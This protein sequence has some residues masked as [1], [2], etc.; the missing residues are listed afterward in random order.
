MTLNPLYA[1]IKFEHL[2]VA[3][4]LSQSVVLCILQ[5]SQG[6]MW[7]GTEDGLNKYDGY[8]FTVYKHDPDNSNSLAD[9]YVWSIHE[10]ESGTLWI[11]TSNGL[12]KFD[13]AHETFVHYQH[14]END[15]NSLSHN[16]VRAIEEDHT[17]TLWIGTYGGGL[18]K[19]DRQ[20]EKFVRYQH[21]ENNPHSLSD[22]NIY[23]DGGLYVDKQGSLWIGTEKGGLNKFDRNTD[24]FIHYQHDPKDPNSL[25]NIYVSQIYEDRA[26]TLW[27]ATTEGLNKFDRDTQTFMHYLDDEVNNYIYEDHA[28]MLWIGT[29]G[30][31]LYQFNPKT[32][33]YV[34]YQYDASNPDSLNNN[35]INTIYQ[36][37]AGTLWIGTWGGGVNKIDE[38]KKFKVYQHQANNPNSLSGNAVWE[39][40]EDSHGVLWIGTE[41]S[42]LN[43]F[44][45]QTGKFVHYQSDEKN[46]NS[47][48][49][50]NIYTITEGPRDVLW[51]GTWGGMDKFDTKT[52]TFV[53]YQHD[54]NSLIDNNINHI[55]KDSFGAL[56]IGTWGHGLDRFDPKTETFVHYQHDDK[57]PQ[58][59]SDKQ[60]NVIYEDSL[61]V[62]WIGTVAGLDMFD[63][64]TFVHYQH[65]DNNPNSLSSG[66]VYTIYEDSRSI[67]WVGTSGGGL[68]KFNRATATF[69]HYREKDGGI[70][71]D[72]VNH[73]LEDDQA[74][75]WLSTNKGLSKF[76]PQTETFR[77]YDVSDGLQSNDFFFGSGCKTRSGELLFGGANGFNL[78]HPNEIKDNPFVP[79][80]LITDFQI[81]NQPVSIGGD[82]P[83][84]QHI[85]F[86]KELTLSYQDSVFSF[87]F[88]ALNFTNPQKNQYAY[89]MEGVD[90]DWVYVDSSRRFATYTNLDAGEYVFK[91]KGSNN[92]GVWNEEGTSL[93]ITI[94]PPWWKT[95]WAYLLYIMI[96]LSVIIAYVITQQR[97]LERT[98]AINEQ[99][100]QADKLKDEFLAN[101]SH[102]LRTPLNGIIG[103]A[104]SL[105]DGATGALS[106]KT[107]ANLA[108]IVGSG[109]RLST[110]VNDILDF[111]KLRHHTLELQLKPVALR[112]IVEVV[113]TL[114]QPLVAKKELQ[115]VNAIESD[116]PPANADENRLLQILH[117]LVGNAIKFTDSGRVEISAKVVNHALEVTVSDT[118]IGISPDKFDQIFESFEQAEGGTA[119][120]YGG[121]GLGLTV[122]KQLVELHGGKI[123]M[124]SQVGVGSQFF[125]T[126]PISEEQAPSSQLST[127]HV[128]SS[129][130]EI[131]T[132]TQPDKLTSDQMKILVVDDEPVNLQVLNNYLSLQ[133][134]HIVQANDG[135]EALAL[136]EKGLKP[137]A[138][139]LDVM[140]PKM[141]GYEVAQKLREKWNADEM[142]ILMLTAKNQVADLVA[143][144]DSGANDYL[145]KPFSKDELLARLKTHIQIKELQAAAL[146]LA[147]ENEKRLRQFLEAMPV[148]VQV[149]DAK[150]K[151][152]YLNQRAE[153]IFGKNLAEEV[154]YQAGS[155]KSYSLDKLPLR[156]ALQGET[157]SIDDIEIHGEEQTIPLE[158]WGTPIFDDHNKINYAIAAFQDITERLKRE[159]A[160][161]E[162]EATEAVN[163][164]MTDSIQ[165][166]KIIQSSL[167]PNLEEVKTYLPKHFFL[168]MPREL[169]GGDMLY[170]ESFEEGFILAVIDCTGHGVPGAFMT[171]VASTSLRRITRDEN[172][173]H[174]ADILKRLNY[175]VK[176]SLQQ[177]T[178]HA[179][180]DDGLDVAICWVK[181]QEKTLIF[182]G[183]KLPLYYIDKGQLN[184]IAGDK[185]SLGY[186]SSNL[187][188]T[189]STHTV[190]IEEGMSFYM[191]TDGF[192]D[193]LGGQK[194]FPFGNKR[195][196]KLLMENSQY[197]FDEHSEKMLQAFN[198]Y[199]G[200]HDRQDDV[201]V[202]GFGF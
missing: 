92:D 28:G 195:F 27:I 138:I 4:G 88:V 125:F 120:E 109:K 62:L 134:Y 121:T 137:D 24:T 161:R 72:T 86:S 15:P 51:I 37:K 70:P 26:G 58:S 50:N 35:Y 3:D 73:I 56:W 151:P 106:D 54:D 65:D 36:D 66:Q 178:K 7:F 47:L 22:N 93:K 94:T 95:W 53:H 68:N 160:E 49:N 142:P 75:L 13:L 77:N 122:T 164:M 14:D 105:I 19:F 101:T 188:F 146:R 85:S 148:G 71:N 108:M 64:E 150:G 42:G 5:D 34:H 84:Q 190:S 117:N 114:S 110:L 198:E 80:V 20:T 183:A 21:D 87:E 79:P 113:L 193:Q 100:R 45:R 196:R 144:L 44:D 135:P 153:Q 32:E 202:V 155:Y 74:N 69:S 201:T 61:G 11:G 48:I 167:L 173:R 187:D 10:D 116:L 118:G 166:A 57:N 159:K 16:E 81:F 40:Y 82:S 180:S 131:D 97:K 199:K 1:Q 18:N 78:F 102:E 176:T 169:V 41:G 90:K 189:F 141:T 175:L 124:D 172:C 31:G 83:L 9:N 145:A 30:N 128:S 182:A 67:L 126:I 186:K 96:A 98:H 132:S 91:V 140:M 60:V 179:K 168:W 149:V 130:E 181:P 76:N 6:F 2:T 152:Y 39:I 23:W 107:K 104:E 194:R 139:L 156:R 25:S 136:I 127:I 59:L 99:L 133:N 52:E 157:S 103:I 17:G 143:G 111:S 171:M 63:R 43:K 191:S 162:R 165:Y 185:H 33:T 158:I 197:P 192:L 147:K 123:L 174:P 38:A 184:I 89:K 170:A 112:E 55:H 177:D 163:K 200:E 119:R 29:D 129:L 154:M 12:D 8:K 115:L 46:P